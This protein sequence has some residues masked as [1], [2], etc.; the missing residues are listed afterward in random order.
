K[1]GSSRNKRLQSPVRSLVSSGLECPASAGLQNKKLKKNHIMDYKND[2]FSVGV[3][4]NAPVSNIGNDS[5]DVAG[6]IPLSARALVTPASNTYTLAHRTVKARRSGQITDIRLLHDMERDGEVCDTGFRADGVRHRVC[7]AFESVKAFIRNSLPNEMFTALRYFEHERNDKAPLHWGEVDMTKL[8]HFISS[9]CSSV[10]DLFENEARLLRLASPCYIVG[11]LH[12]NY[13]DLICFEKVLWREG[14]GLTPA[15]FLFLGD[16]VDR[17]DYGIEVVSYPF[18]QKLL[19]PTTFFLLRGNHEKDGSSRN[20]RLQSPVRSLVSSGLECPASAGLQNK[21]LKK[22]HIMDHKNDLFSVGVSE[23]APVSNIGNDSQDVAGSI[24]LSARALV[25][26]ASNTYTLAHR[27]VKARRSGQITDISLLHDME[28]D[29]EVCDT[30]F[31][32]DGVRHRECDAF[33]SVEAFIRNSLPNEMFTA[34]RYFEH[35]RNDKA[36]SHW[37]EVKDGSSRNKRLQSPV[38]SLVSSG[39]E[40]PASAG[41]QNKKLKKNHIMDHKN[42]LFSV[43]VSENAPVSNIGNDFQDVAGSIPLSARALVTPA[44]N[45]YTLAHRTVKARRSGQITDIRLLLIW[46]VMVKCVILDFV[47]MAYAI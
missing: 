9:L 15:N 11:D 20:K 33:E 24:P 44:S 12:G 43:G 30:G 6:S 23:N 14:P 22:N 18:S 35:E 3:S 34:L 5:Q 21:K 42:D 46:N 36:P 10:K 27:T 2:L 4:E 31:R 29:G 41:L 25:T 8:A 16:Y 37:G 32:A 1:D 17:G 28:R 7:D 38:R 40:C 39:L 19:N 45:T 26:P 13:R 47:L